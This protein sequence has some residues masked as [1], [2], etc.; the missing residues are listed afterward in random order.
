MDEMKNVKLVHGSQF[1]AQINFF[2]T[3]DF[4]FFSL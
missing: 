1:N 3:D 2:T 4:V